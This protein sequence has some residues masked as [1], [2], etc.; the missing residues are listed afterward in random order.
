M[1][2]SLT[3]PWS[4]YHGPK[5]NRISKRNLTS[6]VT[7]KGLLL[8]VVV[9][10]PDGPR[11]NDREWY[12]C[13]K[14]KGQSDGFFLHLSLLFRSQNTTPGISRCGKKSLSLF[15]A[16]HQRLPSS[17]KSNCCWC[18]LTHRCKP[19]LVTMWIFLCEWVKSWTPADDN[20][21]RWSGLLTYSCIMRHSK[22]RYL[23]LD[24]TNGT[25]KALPAATSHMYLSRLWKCST[26]L[27]MHC[28]QRNVKRQEIYSLGSGLLEKCNLSRCSR[29]LSK[30]LCLY[31]SA[32]QARLKAKR[33][34]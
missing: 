19:R 25:M 20:A 24:D 23:Y 30:P 34:K 26:S 31:V 14:K 6:T 17:V 2:R 28:H 9:K 16:E 10:L 8:I 5:K 1:Q 15:P 4:F 11:H 33:S 7:T 18:A 21:E 32:L 22:S 3:L 12:T 27:A 13:G 29:L